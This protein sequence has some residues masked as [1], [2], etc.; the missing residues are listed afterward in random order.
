MNTTALKVSTLL[1]VIWIGVQVWALRGISSL[2]HLGDSSES[3]A[4]AATALQLIMWVGGP[5]LMLIA[6]MALWGLVGAVDPKEPGVPVDPR[7]VRAATGSSYLALFVFVMTTWRLADLLYRLL[8]S[9]SD[10]PV[11]I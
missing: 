7:W 9:A 11:S 8:T 6:G 10:P 2:R 4:D 3:L 1:T 5:L